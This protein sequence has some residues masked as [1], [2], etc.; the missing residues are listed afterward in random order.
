[1]NLRELAPK[2]SRETGHETVQWGLAIK[3]LK[4]LFTAFPF[5]DSEDALRVAR[6]ACIEKGGPVA[7]HMLTP[8][9]ARR[10]FELAEKTK[11]GRWYDQNESVHAARVYEYLKKYGKRPQ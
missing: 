8:A 7:L 10:L 3:V 4:R 9:N 1:M 6:M 11:N 2:F 5:W